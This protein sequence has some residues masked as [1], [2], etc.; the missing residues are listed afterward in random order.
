MERDPTRPS[1]IGNGLDDVDEVEAS[2][3]SGP[4]TVDYV[5]GFVAP[6]GLV[7]VVAAAPG[8]SVG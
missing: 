7:E 6:Q 3:P 1:L 4:V 8:G 2:V 5:V